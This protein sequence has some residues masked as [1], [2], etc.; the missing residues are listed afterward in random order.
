MTTASSGGRSVL[1]LQT[2]WIET[3]IPIVIDGETRG[4]ATLVDLNPAIRS[5]FLLRLENLDGSQEVFHLENPFP[6][7]QRLELAPDHPTGIV[8]V[9]EGDTLACGLWPLDP[10][11][12]LVIARNTGRPYS[13]LC[14]GRIFLR[15]PAVGRRTK[16]EWAADLL[17]DRVRYGDRVTNFIKERMF[18][19]RY[20]KT[21]AREA[22][23]GHER[24]REDN[25]GPSPLRTSDAASTLT[26]RP[27]DLNFVI[28][29]DPG[30]GVE[31][32]RWYPVDG[33]PGIFL[34]AVTA[35]LVSEE[36][37]ELQKGLVNALDAVESKALV[38]LVAFDLSF[39]DLGFSLG[40][41]HP[42][43]GWSD[44]VP[45]ASRDPSLPGPDGFDAIAPLVRTGKL[46]PR[47]VGGVAA[48][49]AGGF[50]RTH[51]AFKWGQLAAQNHGSH[52]GFVESGVILSRLQ[53]GLATFL[54]YDDGR[55]EMKTWTNADALSVWRVRHARQNGVP[56]LEPSPLTGAPQP[57]ALVRDWGR[58][59]WS[60]S[61]EGNLRTLRSGV[62]LQ[63]AGEKRF[64]IYGYF[65]SV[66]PSA[67]SR[68]FQA[69]D[70]RYAMQLDLNA[71]EH[72][73]LA[74]YRIEE[75]QFVVQRLVKEMAEVDPPVDGKE[76][77]R[78]VAYPDNRDFFYLLR[79]TEGAETE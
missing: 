61:Q 30:G 25:M 73:Y 13:S 21:G 68:V 62:C 24:A 77:P 70:C 4:T 59:N 20:L 79:R 5:W 50:K 69:C 48:T 52:Y 56:L 57:G 6:E 31:P 75:S 43:V 16:K 28:P 71:P 41:D 78:F 58:G 49:F 3:A 45:E 15:H 10:Q 37:V 29:T 26:L 55:V 38:Y 18:R 76:L 74:V 60:G 39:F 53:P 8:L 17:R 46:N 65:S 34:S 66:T 36:I 64:L 44:R 7:T 54:V 51:G 32:G 2:R 22:R 72:T 63:E 19:D 14:D 12:P 9:Q 23:L 40:T 11:S 42:R 47:D 33:Y 27:R 1:D 35:D 67:M